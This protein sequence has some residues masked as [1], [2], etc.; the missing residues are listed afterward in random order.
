M[1]RAAMTDN[2]FS[3]EYERDNLICNAIDKP[4][5]HSLYTINTILNTEHNNY[6]L[7]GI[8]GSSNYNSLESN[9]AVTPATN[10]MTAKPVFLSASK[11]YNGV[12]DLNNQQTHFMNY[13]QNKNKNKIKINL[14]IKFLI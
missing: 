9:P 3:N 5:L 4:S 11:N 2:E 8:V 13:F 10:I 1:K 14:R 12:E 7:N 6:P